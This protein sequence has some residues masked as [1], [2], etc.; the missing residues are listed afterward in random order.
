MEHSK[1]MNWDKLL[2][3]ARFDDSSTHDTRDVRSPFQ[4]DI[5]RIVFSSH[6]RRLGRK[7]Q[8]HPLNENDHIHTRLSHSIETSS[9]GRSLGQHV[10]IL[11]KKNSELPNSIAEEHVG[12]IVQAACL[13]HDIGNPPFGH[14]GEAAIK[15]WFKSKKQALT[16]DPILLGTKTL[17]LSLPIPSDI[18][19]TITESIA[20]NAAEASGINALITKDQCGDF[21]KFDGNAMAFRVVTKT[22][23]DAG[24]NGMR[25]TYAM[26]G[27]MLK[28][29]YL[30]EYADKDKFGCFLSE[31]DILVRAAKELGLL[32]HHG[33]QD[34][35][36]RHPLAYLVEAADDI[37]YRIMDIEDGV[38]L[39]LVQSDFL[40]EKIYKNHSHEDAGEFQKGATR[41]VNSKIRAKIMQECIFEIVHCFE[42]NYDAIMRGEFEG[43]LME[44]VSNNDSVCKTVMSQYSILSNDLFLSRRKVELEIG[45]R[46][47]IGRLLDCFLSIVGDICNGSPHEAE[48]QVAVFLGKDKFDQLK[49]Q[50]DCPYN[51]FLLAL[52][53]VTGMTDHYAVVL[54]KRFAGL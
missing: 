35:Y 32:K 20:Q 5:D 24:S 22:G 52:D 39:R 1:R 26:L 53:Y 23:F 37:C 13:A 38:E 47:T 45:A 54:S 4:K 46:M 21:L 15:S 31:K 34:R 14:A 19:K 50:A 12:Q 7:T 8:V 43:S 17:L 3:P 51:A 36:S 48:N 29:P 10:G 28:Y 18:I 9:V 16:S 40:Y 42:A 44:C 11:L 30:S 6:F 27:A 33:G 2:C 49:E 25:P 41:T